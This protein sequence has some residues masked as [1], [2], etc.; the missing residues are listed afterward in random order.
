MTPRLVAVT[1][2]VLSAAVALGM[3]VGAL[4]RDDAR[5]LLEA[6]GVGA[7][8]SAELQAATPT[9]EPAQTAPGRRSATLPATAWEA[10]ERARTAAAR[11]ARALR[12]A[13]VRERRR[14]AARRAA[15]AARAAVA[16]T[17]RPVQ[18]AA[19]AAV[20]AAPPRAPTP[21]PRPAPAAE[22]RQAPPRPRPAP[23]A[24]PRQAP[25]R[26]APTPEA[27]PSGVADAIPW[28]LLQGWMADESDGD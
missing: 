26:P 13:A 1:M 9:S 25:E 27:D 10:R 17:P 18:P 8:A 14:A 20:T 5:D 7:P 21:R 28:D 16:H 23:P 6:A 22:R 12:A 3:G 24:E 11:S 15:G 4:V 2:A 19:T